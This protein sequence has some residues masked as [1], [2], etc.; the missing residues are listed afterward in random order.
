MI[1]N[2]AVAKRQNK[3]SFVKKTCVRH[4][5]YFMPALTSNEY[6]VAQVE[7]GRRVTIPDFQKTKKN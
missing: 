3:V 1:H 6:P 5:M 7:T 2:S 4:R